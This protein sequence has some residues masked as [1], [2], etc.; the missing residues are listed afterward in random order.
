VLGIEG[1]KK[2]ETRERRIAKAVGMLRE[3]KTG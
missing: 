2:A 3:R 1:A